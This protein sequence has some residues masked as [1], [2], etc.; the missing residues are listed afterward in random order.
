MCFLR[1]I[2][3]QL[4]PVLPLSHII[5]LVNLDNELLGLITTVN[6]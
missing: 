3:V 4:P 2:H 6:G 1:R 5:Y